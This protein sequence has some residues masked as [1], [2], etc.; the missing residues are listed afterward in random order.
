[1]FE[2]VL[3][4]ARAFDE[5][6]IV[7][8]PGVRVRGP[9]PAAADAGK[10]NKSRAAKSKKGAVAASSGALIHR[11][12]SDRRQRLP[13]GQNRAARS[14]SAG[15]SGRA[16]QEQEDAARLDAEA[17]AEMLDA[18][19]NPAEML[20]ADAKADAEMVDAEADAGR[21]QQAPAE[22]AALLPAE[23]LYASASSG[24][25][26]E[27][28][29][30]PFHLQQPD[31][32][33]SPE[34][35]AKKWKELKRTLKKEMKGKIQVLENETEKLEQEWADTQKETKRVNA[36]LNFEKGKQV[37]DQKKLKKLQREVAAERKKMSRLRVKIGRQ[38]ARADAWKAEGVSDEMVDH[39]FA[40]EYPL[41]SG[42]EYTWEEELQRVVDEEDDL[43]LDG[44]D[45]EAG[46]RLR[47]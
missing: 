44:S 34:T 30:A 41:G 35:R 8:S 22:A 46:F 37:H 31:V 3:K 7:K 38:R 14:K 45:N 19:V 1:M 27:V 26:P 33:F 12:A 9:F 47:W 25:A 36:L 32:A 17:D 21:R 15:A 4:R 16:N 20:D 39:M 11:E 18:D 23:E 28:L 6:P 5:A 42:E 29:H 13:D 10:Q 43:L 24:D 2:R 40:V